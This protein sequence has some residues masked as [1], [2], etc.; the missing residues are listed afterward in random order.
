VID[1]ANGEWETVPDSGGTAVDV[2]FAP[3]DRLRPPLERGTFYV[4]SYRESPGRAGQT[5]R[6]TARFVRET[7]RET[8][9]DLPSQTAGSDEWAFNFETGTIAT[10]Y[11]RRAAQAGQDRANLELAL[12]AEQAE[13]IL[14][15]P[16]QVD[17][18]SEEQV[19]DGDDF[20][21]DN[22]EDDVQT[23]TINR[24]ADYE[25]KWWPD[26]GDYVVTGWR[27]TDF[28]PP[29]VIVELDVRLAAGSLS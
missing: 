1:D 3:P 11:V 15:V 18:V 23:V 6:V 10:Q 25:P 5:N 7:P 17:A 8:P 26:D 21:R 13:V 14:S 19:P 12:T 16:N 28:G 4:R 27:V 22:T 20:V 2:A 9:S 29:L 24:P